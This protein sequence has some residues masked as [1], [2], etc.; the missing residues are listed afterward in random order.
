M[1]TY[2]ASKKPLENTI[3]EELNALVYTKMFKNKK[4]IQKGDL[5]SS[6]HHCDILVPHGAY[7]PLWCMFKKTILIDFSNL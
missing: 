1:K 2:T 7:K 4:G 6:D 5:Y 3:I